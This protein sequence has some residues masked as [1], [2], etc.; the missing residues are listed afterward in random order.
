MAK[1]NLSD[2]DLKV[3]SGC[4]NNQI[5]VPQDLL[6]KLSPGFFEKLAADGRFDFKALDK[7]KIPTIFKN[8][9]LILL[10]VKLFKIG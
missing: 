2:D 7:F 1:I 4:I 3:L 9:F 6:V 10:R 8:A 5:E